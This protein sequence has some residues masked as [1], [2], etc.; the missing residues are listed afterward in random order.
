MSYFGMG[1]ENASSSISLEE[2]I[3]RLTARKENLDHI[4]DGSSAT[5]HAINAIRREEI[6]HALEVL[7]IVR[8]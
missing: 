4:Y 5:S 2:A 3:E 8:S 1:S 7:R 6:D